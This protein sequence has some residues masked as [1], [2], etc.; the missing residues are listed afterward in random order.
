MLLAERRLN[1]QIGSINPAERVPGTAV[2]TQSLL[3]TWI[4]RPRHPTVCG[5]AYLLAIVLTSL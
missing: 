5:G 3:W 1:Y 4:A 2:F